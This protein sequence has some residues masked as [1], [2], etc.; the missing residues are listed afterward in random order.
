MDDSLVYQGSETT[1]LK[2]FQI[3]NQGGVLT[4]RYAN[5]NLRKILIRR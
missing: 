3:A 2:E 4:M 1:N 5:Q